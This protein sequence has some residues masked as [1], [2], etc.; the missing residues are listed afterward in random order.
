MVKRLVFPF[1]KSFR[2][3]S[4]R[5]DHSVADIL[6]APSETRDRL[7]DGIF[8]PSDPDEPLGRSEEALHMV[9]AAEQIEK[10]IEK[11]VKKGTIQKGF[12]IDE[13]AEALKQNIITDD[14]AVVL[15]S[16]IEIRNE[17]IKVD[18]FP[19]DKWRR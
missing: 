12:R 4:D 13:L 19:K 15:K 11:A 2:A 1:G 10:K 3:P 18:D 9:I 6:L 7:T 14:E 17:V 5:L 16:A 8:I